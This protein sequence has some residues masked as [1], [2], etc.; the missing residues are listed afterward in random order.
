[1]VWVGAYAGLRGTNVYAWWSETIPLGL[2][3]VAIWRRG[4]ARLINDVK[5]LGPLWLAMAV[6]LTALLVPMAIG[7]KGSG[8]TSLSLGSC[9]AADYAA[10]ARVFKEFAHNDR[11]GFLGL[12]E[13]VSVM[14]VDNFFDFW[15]RLNHF[16]PSALIALNGTVLDCSPHELTSLLTAVLL[17]LSLPV[18]F[19]LGRSVLNYSGRSSLWVAYLYGFSPVTWYAVFQVA[20]GQLIAAQAIALIT[21]AGVM[22]W[23]G[24]L[25]GR[26]GRQWS[27]L[28]FI[29]YAL[30]LGSY[31]FILLV[32]WI[33]AVAFAGGLAL[34]FNDWH[35]FGRWLLAMALPLVACGLF[36]FERVLGLAERFRLFQTYDFGWRIPALT[37]E[38]WLG[39]VTGPRLEGFVLPVRIILGLMV[40]G[41]IAT[42]FF[43]GVRRK[44]WEAFAAASLAVPAIVG[45]VYLNLRGVKLGT[46]ASY[47]AYKILS[48]FFPGLLA[49]TCYWLTLASGRAR[50][51]R[52]VVV[53]MA[54]VAS[55]LTANSAYRFGER[56]ESPPLIVGRGLTEVGKVE[57]MA[58]VTSVNMR[59][60]DMWSRLWANAFLLRRPQYFASHTYEGRLNTPLRGEWDLNGGLFEVRLPDGGSRRINSGFWLADTRSRYF[61]RARVGE[62]WHDLERQPLATQRWRWTKGRAVITLE[63]AQARPL[64]VTGRLLNVHSLEDRD[65]QIWVGNHRL[66][67]VRVTTAEAT[68]KLPEL[69]LPTGTTAL[70]IRSATPPSHVPGDSRE[71]GFRIFGVELDV[72]PDLP[73][74]AEPP[75]TPALNGG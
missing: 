5:R 52:Y 55:V 54:V 43:I 15:L 51:A 45:Y 12:T 62:G 33:P 58:D 4:P 11:S 73:E 20:M 27:A 6:C 50:R 66:K 32:A 48:V 22:L 60:P 75:K 1:V 65:L 30:I 38:G 25:T 39:M 2:L 21:L 41:L 18:V 56:M 67:T 63:N 16:T 53:T 28:L 13:V 69:L 9:D 17:V 7:A 10:G 40:V 19:W 35:R 36:F 59:M 26:N 44:R 42:A 61:L 68:I 29:G 70:E 34:W 49:A 47:D 74:T 24:S 23:R 8:L 31:N 72:L 46:N 37:P 57:S 64:R 71:L 3:A 14:S